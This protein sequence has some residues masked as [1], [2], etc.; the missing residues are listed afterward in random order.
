MA[1]Y[2]KY[3]HRLEGQELAQS[4]VVGL[5]ME[6]ERKSVE[7]MSEKVN[8]SERSMQRLLTEVK[9]DDKGVSQECRRI[10]LAQTCEAQGILA[11][12]DTAFTKK[13]RESVCV[14][15]QSCRAKGKVDNCQSGVS[16]TYFGQNVA[17]PYA[18]DLFVPKSW[19]NPDDGQCVVRRKK[20]R[21]PDTA[22]YKEKWKIALE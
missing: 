13:V 11:V 3:F 19:D 8:A 22:H 16:L 5:M 9:W 7:P 4:Y 1:A 15:R 6:G 2:F 14:V 21:M 10:M 17:G 12:D 20:T 18:M